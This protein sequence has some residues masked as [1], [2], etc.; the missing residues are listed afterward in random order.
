MKHDCSLVLP[1][2]ST[3]FIDCDQ[4]A[5]FPDEA[6]RPDLVALV[7]ES[8]PATYRW[9]VIEMKA[10]AGDGAKIVRQLQAG[11]DVI[12]EHSLFARASSPR[13]VEGFV[14]H[15]RGIKTAAITVINNSGIRFKGSRGRI[16]V[17]RCGLKIG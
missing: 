2:R 13:F 14:L 7:G 4:C 15:G 3:L 6:Q 5:A 10:K 1:D 17:G 8:D 12:A 11:A 9:L 16:R